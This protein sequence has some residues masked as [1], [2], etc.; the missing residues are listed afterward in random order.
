MVSFSETSID[1]VVCQCLDITISTHG[2]QYNSNASINISMSIRR[3]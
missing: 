2:P 3:L 1:V